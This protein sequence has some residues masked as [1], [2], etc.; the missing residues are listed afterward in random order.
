MSVPRKIAITG[1]TGFLGSTLVQ[2]FLKNGDHV[3][4]LVRAVPTVQL[5][6]VSYV[7][8]DLT[9][10][11][12]TEHSIDAEVLIHAAYIPVT[13]SQN[14]FDQNTN[15]TTQLLK[16]FSLATKKLFISSISA[17]AG[18]PAIYGQQ[19]A[20]IENMFLAE[21][22][23]AIRPGLILGNGG[24]F[25]NMSTYLK[26]KRNIPI[27]SGGKQ[28][29]QTVYVNDLVQ[30]IDKLITKDLKGIFTFCEHEPVDYRQFYTELCK[31][32]G[33]QPRFISIPFWV[34]DCMVACANIIG[35]KLPINKDNLQGLK[36]MSAKNSK[37]D[38]EKIGVNTGNYKEN[39]TRSIK[40]LS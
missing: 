6:G 1:A 39:I 17:D 21:N 31:Q 33:V 40:D 38:I 36:L 9:T 37:E 16:L 5:V 30:A 12:C 23:A 15:G 19:K 10:G 29:V 25:A 11:A 34:A 7:Q 13:A 3:I 22:G 24:L 8:F 35:V 27:F 14:A 18:S 20:A 2:H 4:A 32:L 28:P 26:T